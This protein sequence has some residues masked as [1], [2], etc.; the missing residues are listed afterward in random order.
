[1][2]IC[3]PWRSRRSVSQTAKPNRQVFSLVFGKRSQQARNI[4]YLRFA[5]VPQLAESTVH[6]FKE[7]CVFHIYGISGIIGL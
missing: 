5:E 7:L 3:S 2:R 6:F 4:S 1:M